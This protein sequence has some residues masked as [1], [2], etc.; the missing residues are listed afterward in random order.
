MVSVD[1]S[2]VAGR[3]RW[4]GTRSLRT[5]A[6]FTPKIM[7]HC[8]EVWAYRSS[9]NAVELMGVVLSIESARTF[10][11]LSFLD[12]SLRVDATLAVST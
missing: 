6:L 2:A 3:W 8:V 7:E 11:A 1:V 9:V 5:S 12:Y 4:L 10:L